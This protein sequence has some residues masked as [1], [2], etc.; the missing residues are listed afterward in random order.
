MLRHCLEPRSDEVLLASEEEGGLSSVGCQEPAKPRSKVPYEKPGILQLMMWAI[1]H[2]NTLGK[3][4]PMLS[5][6]A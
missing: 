1:S 3:L 2:L 4:E 6:L 5:M